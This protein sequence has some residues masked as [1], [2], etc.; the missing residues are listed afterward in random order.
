M[1]GVLVESKGLKKEKRSNPEWE[2]YL[3]F[4]EI[5]TKAKVTFIFNFREHFYVLNNI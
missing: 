4:G 2:R 3:K 5:R 1:Y